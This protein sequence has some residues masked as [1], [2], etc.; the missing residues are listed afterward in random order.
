[1]KKLCS[2]LSALRPW[3]PLVLRLIIGGLFLW[4]G[5]DKFRA[6]IDMVESMFNMWGVPAP[7]LA[8]PA[9][10]IIEIVGGIALIIG[11]GTR[12]AAMMLSVIMLGALIFVKVD[13]GLIPMDAAGA[14]VDLAYLAGLLALV[15]IGPGPLSVDVAQGLEPNDSGR[16]GAPALVD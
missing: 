13:V 7:A 14:E 9:V 1:M 6:G 8:A 16:G 12:A 11:A 3:G 2:T 10:A 5:I 15:A 4:H